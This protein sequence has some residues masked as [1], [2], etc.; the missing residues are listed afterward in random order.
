MDL[1]LIGR[2]IL[3]VSGWGTVVLVLLVAIGILALHLYIAHRFRR[4]QASFA[5]E[6]MPLVRVASCP[7]ARS[8]PRNG[9]YWYL[10]AAR[11]IRAEAP[12]NE[13]L[14]QVIKLARQ[15]PG[16]WSAVVVRRVT[17]ALAAQQKALGWA[18]AGASRPMCDVL[19]AL[20]V[21]RDA[22]LPSSLNRLS[23]LLL[24]EAGFELRLGNQERAANAAGALEAL[25][26]GLQSGPTVVEEMV[27]AR[28]MGSYLHA[29]SWIVESDMPSAA[30]LEAL[31]ARLPRVSA[32]EVLARVLA[33]EGSS[34]FISFQHAGLGRG[35]VAGFSRFY[36]DPRRTIWRDHFA[37]S[38]LEEYR[39]RVAWS[40]LT[41]RQLEQAVSKEQDN[42]VWMGLDAASLIGECQAVESSLQLAAIALDLRIGAAVSGELP[43]HLP[44]AQ[45]ALVDPFAGAHPVYSKAASGARVSNPAAAAE[46]PELTRAMA[47]PF[48]WKLPTAARQP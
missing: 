13:A 41:H 31:R 2:R 48:A 33:N 26:L 35:I 22:D 46:Y 21:F 1:N 42:D 5:R 28:V 47:P 38:Q 27:G 19:P 20:D 32:R 11:S 24:A 45:A 7:Y 39:H 36:A 37:T 17:A 23:D 12:E 43:A 16:T 25:G 9:A 34:Y 15:S 30:T 14:R 4:A 8:D 6:V 44:A 3:R 10:A 18:D 40:S 29:L